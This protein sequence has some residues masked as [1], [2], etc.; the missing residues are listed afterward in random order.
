MQFVR[1]FFVFPTPSMFCL[2][3]YFSDSL[4]F[5]TPIRGHIASALPSPR[6]GACL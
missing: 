5:L 3:T 6:Y 4:P 2:R 1:S